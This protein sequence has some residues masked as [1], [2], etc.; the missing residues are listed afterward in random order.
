MNDEWTWRIDMVYERVS[1]CHTYKYIIRKNKQTVYN[2][3]YSQYDE[4]RIIKIM[5]KMMKQT[6]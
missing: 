1:K 4:E 6:D 5:S 2:K 3:E